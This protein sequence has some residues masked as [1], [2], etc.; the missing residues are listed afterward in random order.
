M[1]G[2]NDKELDKQGRPTRAVIIEWVCRVIP[3]DAYRAYLP[4]EVNAA[5]ALIELVDNAQHVDEFPEFEDQYDWI[6]PR[7]EFAIRHML[8]LRKL[9]S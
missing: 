8:A 1:G 3:N 5:L 7:L 2:K 9:V 6:M 4:T